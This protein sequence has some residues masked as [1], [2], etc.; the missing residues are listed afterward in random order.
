MTT[1]TTN[2]PESTTLKSILD[3]PAVKSRFADVLKD[4]SAGFISS[5]LSLAASN[6]NF[7]KCDPSSI[8]GAAAIAATLD[9][10]INPSLGQAW[11][12]PYGNK[13]QFQIGYKGLVQLA[14][15]SRQYER[16]NVIEVKAGQLVKFNQLTEECEFDFTKDDGEVVGYA[17]FFRL[18]NG[19]E[20]VMYWNVAR[21]LAHAKKHSKTYGSGP[22]QTDFPGMAMKT[23][24]KMILNKWGILSIEMQKAVEVDQAVI[25]DHAGETFAY[26]DAV[27]TDITNQSLITEDHNPAAGAANTTTVVPNL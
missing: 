19:F 6:T 17:A 4:K 27:H 5:I 15:R 1:T 2:L 11:I 8:V 7:S 24:L 26:E 9:L 12:I 3:N 14:L 13:A 22:W 18:T 23:L 25:H 20:K 21:V 16:M 10:S